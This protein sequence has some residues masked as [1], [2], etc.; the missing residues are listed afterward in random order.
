MTKQI[1]ILDRVSEPSDNSFRFALWAVVPA[2]RVSWYGNA[3]L[4]SAYK[5]ISAQ[6]LADL[7]A[8]LFAETVDTFVAPTG[9]AIAAMRAELIARFNTFQAQITARNPTVRYGTF[10]DGATWTA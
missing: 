2:T 6:E 9:T 4:A 7:R 3:T 5:D 8:G 1:I 10:F